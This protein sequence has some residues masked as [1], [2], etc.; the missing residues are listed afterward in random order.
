LA[1][2]TSATMECHNE[3]SNEIIINIINNLINQVATVKD[4]K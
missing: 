1:E 3:T 2:R 4:M